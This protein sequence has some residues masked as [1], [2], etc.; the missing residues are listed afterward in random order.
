MI[1]LRWVLVELVLAGLLLL[2]VPDLNRT[3]GVVL[4][5]LAGVWLAFT[6]LDLRVAYLRARARL[7]RSDRVRPDD[8]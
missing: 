4:S 6:V 5:L 1:P 8:R 2:T 7:R 3:Q